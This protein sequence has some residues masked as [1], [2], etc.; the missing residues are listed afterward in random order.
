MTL[1][2]LSVAN[3]Q[4]AGAG[5]E[6]RVDGRNLRAEQTRRKIVVAT[7]ALVQD[8][9]A[10]PKV[11]DIALRAGVSVRSVF[12]H[13]QEVEML[14]LVVFDEILAEAQETWQPVEPVGP[15]AQRIEMLVA[16]RAAVCERAL[17]VRVSAVAIEPASPALV[18]RAKV[19]RALVR[20]HIERAF[21]PE[22]DRLAPASRRQTLDALRAALDW[23]M[24]TNMRR[25]HGLSAEDAQGVWHRIVTAIMTADV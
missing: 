14:F 6:P 1:L 22:L 24:W 16:R 19:A 12:Q 13:F 10:L 2:A 5:G 11:A 15:L 17:P 25:F 23:D 9:M 18:E 3:P 4:P 8:M 20:Q 7:R 21:R